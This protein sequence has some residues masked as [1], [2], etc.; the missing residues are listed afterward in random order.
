MHGRGRRSD[1]EAAASLRAEAEAKQ[2]AHHLAVASAVSAH[3]FNGGGAQKAAPSAAVEETADELRARRKQQHL[4][5]SGPAAPAAPAG[6]VGDG[7]FAIVREVARAGGVRRAVKTYEPNG[8]T[9]ALRHLENEL[10]LAGRIRHPNILGPD[11]VRRLGGDSVEIEMDYAA[12]GSLSDYLKRAKYSSR[13]GAAL[14]ETEAAA[15]ACGLVEALL[16]L[17]HHGISHGDVKL[18]NAM[19]DGGI[20]RLID[21]GTAVHEGGGAPAGA[22]LPG[23]LACTSPEALDGAHADG[24]PADVWALGVLLYNLLCRGEYPFTGRDEAALRRSIQTA[25]VKLPDGLTAAC[26]D[27]LCR[28]FDKDTR[29]RITIAA[30]RTHPWIAAARIKGAPSPDPMVAIDL[31]AQMAHLQLAAAAQPR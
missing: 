30:V 22:R 1:A 9:M 17:H 18:G 3:H 15:L 8:D 2:R 4:L 20:V 6:R 5:G 10:S 31:S 14:P 23:T 11:E 27:L 24:R 13:G 19:L 12:G 28:M 7:A 29:S 26:R 25:T 21:F 16:Y